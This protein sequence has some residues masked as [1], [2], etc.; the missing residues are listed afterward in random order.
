MVE[1]FVVDFISTNQITAFYRNVKMR[2]MF[3]HFS[4]QFHKS[5]IE[6]Q[7]KKLKGL[8]KDKSIDPTR[9]VQFAEEVKVN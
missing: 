7:L 6:K 3:Y 2:K 4:T 5:Q 8:N 1:F 9:C